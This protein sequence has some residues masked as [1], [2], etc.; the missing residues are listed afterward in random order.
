[1]VAEKISKKSKK[2]ITISPLSPLTESNGKVLLM[3]ISSEQSNLYNMKELNKQYS[4]LLEEATKSIFSLEEKTEASISL[5]LQSSFDKVYAS[6][7]DSQVAMNI[8]KAKKAKRAKKEN[9]PKKALS[10]YMVFCMRNRSEVQ[11][12]NPECKPTDVSKLLGG[13]WNKLTPDQKSKFI[14][15]TVSN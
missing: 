12:N 7:L 10:N 4:K 13:M 15:T 1:M 9:E 6:V 14:D 8:K 11:A 3:P 5:A 2:D